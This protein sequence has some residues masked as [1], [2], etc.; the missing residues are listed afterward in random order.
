MDIKVEVQTEYERFIIVI[1]NVPENLTPGQLGGQTVTHILGA[2]E[3]GKTLFQG[4]EARE[5][6]VIFIN[7]GANA[8]KHIVLLGAMPETPAVEE[9]APEDWKEG[10]RTFFMVTNFAS[11]TVR[12]Q[13]LAYNYLNNRRL[14]H[15]TQSS[16]YVPILVNDKPALDV[17]SLNNLQDLMIRY[18]KDDLQYD[19]TVLV[20]PDALTW[21]Q[22][23]EYAADWIKEE[24]KDTP[25]VAQEKTAK[26]WYGHKRSGVAE[27]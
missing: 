26:A 2:V 9:A 16:V 27:E 22:A 18:L 10:P 4:A 23:E 6:Q 1:P 24:L 5:G 12:I 25:Y 3:E 21:A 11:Q 19:Y 17:I 13:G 20:P 15:S 7:G 8:V 14:S